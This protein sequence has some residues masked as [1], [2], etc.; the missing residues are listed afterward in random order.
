MALHIRPGLRTR[1]LVL[2]LLMT[3][4]IWAGACAESA[5]S[6]SS[7]FAA[8]ATTGKVATSRAVAVQGTIEATVEGERITWYSV[9]GQSGGAPYSSSSWLEITDTERLVAI[10]GFATDDPPLESF[11]WSDSG[12]P[13]SYGSY[14]GSVFAIAIDLR[15][16]RSEFSVSLP[17]PEGRNQLSYQPRA[18]L[19][20]VMAN[21]LMMSTG[22]L[23]VTEVAISDG[24]ARASGTFSG[25]FQSMEGDRSMEVTNGVFEVAGIPNVEAIR[26]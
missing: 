3:L 21:T 19:E 12:M 1:I 17:D 14:E 9:S 20:N 18:A 11:E 6:S 15:G 16:E 13:T 10:G 2:A 26:R 25:T 5:D 23:S 7:D 24:I 22:T 4:P 8:T